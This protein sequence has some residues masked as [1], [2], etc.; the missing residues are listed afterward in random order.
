MRLA[1]D[2]RLVP[3]VNACLVANVLL[4]HSRQSLVQNP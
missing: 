4:R 1:T 2:T 3:N